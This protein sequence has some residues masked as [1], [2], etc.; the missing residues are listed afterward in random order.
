MLVRAG[1]P[2]DDPLFARVAER[3]ES[4]AVAIPASGPAVMPDVRGLSLRQALLTL[5]RTG[6]LPRVSGTGFVTA[7]MPEPGA[8]IDEGTTSVLSLRRDAGLRE[9]DLR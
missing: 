5:R 6:L 7:Q 2:D 9:G 4:Q 8:P 3:V 1:Q